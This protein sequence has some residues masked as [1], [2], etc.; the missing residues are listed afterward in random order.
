[1]IPSYLT[2][3]K[4]ITSLSNYRTKAVSKYYFEIH[5]RQDLDKVIEIQD[6]ADKND[7]KV[8]FVW[9]WTNMLFAF[10]VFDWIVIKNCLTW[11]TYNKDTKLLE[12]YSGEEISTIAES[13]YNSGQKLWKRFIWLPWSIWWAVFG[14]AWCFWLETENNFLESEVFDLDNW[15]IKT[16]FKKDMDFNY[17][18]SIIKKTSKY[19]IIKASFDLSKLVEKYSSDVDNIEF[20][21]VKQPKWNTCWSFFKNPSRENSAGSLIEKIWLKGKNIWWACFSELHANFLMNDWT[22]HYKDMLNLINL[23]QKQVKKQYNIDLVP[24]IRIIKN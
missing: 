24:E 19:F 16:F 20:R 2:K 17:R 21:E 3:D 18:N 23:A 10:D 1:M 15:E 13:L 12:S 9:W 11:W 6:F 22:A 4:D 14:N 8:L 5:S 7:L